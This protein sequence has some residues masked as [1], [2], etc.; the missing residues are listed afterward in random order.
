M[1]RDLSDEMRGREPRG[2]G[3]HKELAREL[4]HD[5]VQRRLGE[6]APGHRI[7]CHVLGVKGNSGKLLCFSTWVYFMSFMYFS[8]I[9]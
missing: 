7:E 5:A 9:M 4:R 1:V 3:S 6:E 2:R 8:T